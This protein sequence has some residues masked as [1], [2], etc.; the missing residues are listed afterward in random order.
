MSN[1]LLRMARAVNAAFW[2]CPARNDSAEHT[3]FACPNWSSLCDELVPT[4]AISLPQTTYLTCADLTLISSPRIQR[5]EAGQS[6]GIIQS[7]IQNGRKHPLPQGNGRK[8]RQAD[9]RR[10]HMD[11][12]VQHTVREVPNEPPT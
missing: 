1:Y 5:R 4:L 9:R 8:A 2:H 7:V 6:G 3:I 11:T 12:D 10:A